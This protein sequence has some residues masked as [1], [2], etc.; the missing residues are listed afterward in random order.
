MQHMICLL[1]CG[2]MCYKKFTDFIDSM[3]SEHFSSIAKKRSAGFTLVELSAVL[4][5]IGI[6]M[7][8]AIVL[9]L[10]V[11]QTAK[12]I[13][14][15]QKLENIAKAIDYYARQNYRLPCP[16][17]PDSDASTPPFGFE[18]G[19]GPIGNI[20]P[21]N[22]DAA[23]GWEGVVP[24]RTL[25]IPIDWVTDSWGNFITYA[26][27]P[28][29]SQDV[30]NPA[31][32]VHNRCRTADWFVADQIYELGV[33]DP[34]TG[35]DAVNILTPKN[36]YKARF[37][38]S[39]VAPDSDLSILDANEQSQ[40]ASLRQTAAGSYATANITYP[41][42]MVSN[43]QVPNDDRVSAP[44][45]ILVSHGPNG[46]GAYTGQGAGARVPDAGSTV[47]ENENSDGDRIFYEIPK[48]DRAGV[49]QQFDDVTLWRTQ[50]AIFATAAESCSLP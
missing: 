27:S 50:D 49:E 15:D 1:S 9:V 26:I 14:T 17:A 25:N 41:S 3:K 21:A 31:L 35:A 28:G 34:A 48:I 47:A 44:V 29:F 10:P 2:A 38:C 20:I 5:I 13:E 45:Y 23:A 18:Q 30:S 11:M 36:S 4:I 32:P 39:G 24:F 7:A 43:V 33:K 46:N 16:A 8:G 22:C 6:L 42:P 40:M 19:S 12:R 37:C